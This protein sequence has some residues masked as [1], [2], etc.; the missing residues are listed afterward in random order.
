MYVLPGAILIY[1][2]YLGVI[3]AQH[4]VDSDAEI[5]PRSS[6]KRNSVAHYSTHPNARLLDGLLISINPIDIEEWNSSMIVGKI[7]QVIKS[8]IVLVLNICVPVVDPSLELNGWSKL[9]NTSQVIILPVTLSFAMKGNTFLIRPI[10]NESN[11]HPIMAQMSNMFPSVAFVRVFGIE[12]VWYL[13]VFTCIIAVL[14]FTT[15]R[16]DRYP[17]YHIVSDFIWGVILSSVLLFQ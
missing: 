1:L 2:V 8:P 16:T 14:V 17:T 6:M 13:L 12:I 15:S 9:L 7:S 10:N 3:I 4:F 5:E 11:A